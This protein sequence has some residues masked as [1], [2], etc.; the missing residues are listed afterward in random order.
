MSDN[1]EKISIHSLI[2]YANNARTH[3]EA[4][5]AQI[6]ASIKEFGFN[7]PILIDDSMSIIAGHGRY[8]A[9]LKLGLDEVPCLRLSHL[10]ENQRK[11]YVL[12]DNK[13]AMNA[14][15]DEELLRLEL[16]DLSDAEKALTGFSDE[17]MAELFKNVTP[18]DGLPDLPDGDKEPFQQMAFILHDSQAETVNEA[19]AVVKQIADIDTGVNTNS[20]GNALAMICELFLTQNH[21]ND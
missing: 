20:N 10:S 2:P 8:A 15:W 1:L 16:S 14:G 4:Q 7:N 19:I 18:L 17:E 21:T 9:A 13:I 5:V 11:A 12:A 3:N 6:A